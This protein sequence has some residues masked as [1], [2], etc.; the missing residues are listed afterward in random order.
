MAYFNGKEGKWITTET[1]RHVFI[2]DGEDPAEVMKD[3]FDDEIAN[4]NAPEP[5]F[6]DSSIDADISDD[7]FKENQL[8]SFKGAWDAPYKYI[9]DYLI[10]HYKK[11]KIID[12]NLEEAVFKNAANRQKLSKL[13]INTNIRGGSYYNGPRGRLFIEL[14]S[15]PY[16]TTGVLFHEL[17]HC[18]D[19]DSGLKY[20][21][22]TYVSKKY[23][24]TLTKMIKEEISNCDI[25]GLIGE[26][27]S[28]GNLNNSNY[29]AYSDGQITVEERNYY[30]A[31]VY[32]G[33]YLSVCDVIQGTYGFDFVY[34]KLHNFTH[35]R[36]YFDWKSERYAEDA[37]KHNDRN[38]GA[39]FFAEMTEDLCCND[40]HHFSKIMRKYAPK[41][42]DIYFEILKEKYG[43]EK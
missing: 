3:L 14:S 36:E 41:S 28:L 21:S 24:T 13:W 10:E 25:E 9:K 37:E 15:N 1:G 32:Y 19:E 8:K 17:G 27:E 42:V 33:A 30:K 7:D 18:L 43:Y 35:G 40:E 11:H 16:K 23:G 26:Y 6:D 20:H 12:R 2:P 22:N 39:E 34:E 31:K 5:A 29:L 4:N 38:R